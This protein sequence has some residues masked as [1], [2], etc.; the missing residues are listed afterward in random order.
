MQASLLPNI[1]F[2]L[3]KHDQCDLDGVL[4]ECDLDLFTF[5]T[6]KPTKFQYTVRFYKPILINLN[7]HL[8]VLG[9]VATAVGASKFESIAL[10]FPSAGSTISLCGVDEK[11]SSCLPKIVKL[12]SVFIVSSTIIDFVLQ[13]ITKENIIEMGSVREFFSTLVN[14]H[15]DRAWVN[16]RID[17]LKCSLTTTLDGEIIA[18]EIAQITKV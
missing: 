6:S 12:P 13:T 10:I 3:F 17:F 9:S 7:C 11:V 1:K 15:I 5:E 18:N 4:S 2:V 8:S 16:A 14:N